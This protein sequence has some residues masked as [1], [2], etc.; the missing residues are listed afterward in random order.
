MYA[1]GLPSSSSRQSLSSNSG[2]RARDL[3]RLQ[4]ELQRDELPE[5]QEEQDYQNEHHNKGKRRSSVNS[6]GP[7]HYSYTSRPSLQPNDRQLSSGYLRDRPQQHQ[8]QPVRSRRTASNASKT[9]TILS[10]GLKSQSRQ[11]KSSLQDAGR[12]AIRLRASSPLK[13]DEVQTHDSPLRRWCRLVEKSC[14]GSYREQKAKEWAIAVAVI[15]W[16]KWAVGIGSWSGKGYPPLYGDMEAQRHWLSITNHLPLSQW[17][18]HDQQYWGLDYPPL[19]AYHSYILGRIARTF[20]NP[21][22]AEL[23]GR[24]GGKEVVF[25]EEKASMFMRSTVIVGDMLLWM[26]PVALWCAVRLGRWKYRPQDKASAS[27]RS[28]RT[29]MITFYSIMLQ[30]CLIMID[31]GHFQYNSIMLGLTLLSMLSFYAGRDYIGAILFVCSMCFKQM[32]IFYAPGVFAYLLGKCFWLGSSEGLNL[33]INLGVVSTAALLACFAPFLYPLER[34]Q[35]AIARIFPFHR[36]LFE[37]KVANVWCSLNVAIKLRQIFSISTLARLAAVATLGATLPI[38]AGLVWTSIQL[39]PSTSF[40]SGSAVTAAAVNSRDKEPAPTVKLLPHALFASAMA[41]FLFSFQVHEKSILL[42]LMPLTLLIAGKQPGLPGQ[43]YEW[44]VLLNNVGAFSLYPLL[45]RDGL[46]LPAI[47][48]TLFWNY[49]L[50]Y[51][52]FKLSSG[53]VKYLS[54]TCLVFGLALIFLEATI[55]PPPHLPDLFVVLNVVWSCAIFGLGWLWSLTRLV[56]EAWGL[57]GL[58]FHDGISLSVPLSSGSYRRS[59]FS[60][61]VSEYSYRSRSP[62]MEVLEELDADDFPAVGSKPRSSSVASSSRTATRR[63]RYSHMVS[64]AEEPLQEDFL[65]PPRRTPSSS[66]NQGPRQ[67]Q[68]HRNSSI[69]SQAISESSNGFL[70]PSRMGNMSTQVSPSKT[71]VPNVEERYQAEDTD[72]FG[73]Q[74]DMAKWKRATMQDFR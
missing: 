26:I 12:P 71:Y 20:G 23:A 33:F 11:N 14:R 16:V 64:P 39:R 3:H 70:K 21:R 15:V 1:S 36:G 29:L 62:N 44:A 18:W 58:G 22:W 41:F 47:A 61:A 5:H 9:S 6:A 34:L 57:I 30:P 48:L 49:S 2:L 40:D 55:T 31:S 68:H 32:A 27:K 50:G 53:L 10:A 67:R 8:Q 17:Y 46:A 74:A 51:N 42:P 72:V 45:K 43:D 66:T 52:P 4:R 7:S 69:A 38:V 13:L 35:Q 59:T 54:I 56:E 28:S 19:T 63:P 73:D 25:R 37:D 65:G 24:M 60:P